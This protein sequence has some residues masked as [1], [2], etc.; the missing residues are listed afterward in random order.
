MTTAKIRVFAKDGTHTLCRALLDTASTANFITSELANKLKLRKRYCSVPVRALNSLHTTCNYYTQARIQSNH[1]NLTKTLDFFITNSI[2]KFTP[3]NTIN[4]EHVTIPRNIKLADAEFHKAAAIDMLLGSG[5]TL[6]LFS[7]GQIK[8]PSGPKTDLIL[9]KT[10]LVWVI[11]G[12]VPS[13]VKQRS[14]PFETFNLQI[15]LDKFWKIEEG[16]NEQHL[17]AEEQAAED[18]FQRNTTRSSDGRYTVA[19]PFKNTIKSLGDSKQIALK[20]FHTLETRLA[21][22]PELKTQYESIM[23]DYV[24]LGHM[25]LSHDTQPGVY[26]PHHAV[27]KAS[28][29][30]TKIR[31]VFDASARSSS[32]TSLNDTLMTGSTIQDDMQTLLLRFRLHQ[33]V[34]T[35]DIEKMYR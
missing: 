21:K 14:Q 29:Q 10:Q 24:R 9:Q 6:S 11:G 35:G 15:E 12:S 28:S 18:H 8:L 32:G 19:L 23:E 22:D 25:T 3:T 1:N 20:R 13:G 30:A 5:P 2:S 4:R 31:V 16:S 17:T 33:Y 34:I 26:L 7:I 27:I